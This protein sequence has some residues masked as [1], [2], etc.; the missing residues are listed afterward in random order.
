MTYSNYC[1][2]GQIFKIPKTYHEIST[3]NANKQFD[4]NI[5]FSDKLGP[6]N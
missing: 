6:A 3:F 2:Q 1:I 4:L 5:Q